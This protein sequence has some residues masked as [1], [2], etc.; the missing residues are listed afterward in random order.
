MGQRS[1]EEIVTRPAVSDELRRLVVRMQA[2]I[3][4]SPLRVDWKGRRVLD[5]AVRVAA[6]T[7][8][9]RSGCVVTLAMLGLEAAVANRQATLRAVVGAYASSFSDQKWHRTRWF[10]AEADGELA[11]LKLQSSQPRKIWFMQ[12][13]T[14]Q[15]RQG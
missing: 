2:G 15:P 7:V 4:Q 13:F 12:E 11:E 14:I 1:F 8:P 3:W 5:P 10:L 9:L 6:L